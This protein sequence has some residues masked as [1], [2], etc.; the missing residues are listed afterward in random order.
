MAFD[1]ES[2]QFCKFLDHFSI[3]FEEIFSSLRFYNEILGNFRRFSTFFF[4]LVWENVFST[5]FDQIWSVFQDSW[6]LKTEFLEISKIVDNLRN[7]FQVWKILGASKTKFWAILKDFRRLFN[8]VWENVFN[9][10]RFLAFLKEFLEFW[11]IL[12]GFSI[13][14]GQ[15]LKIIDILKQN[16]WKFRRLSTIFRSN[17]INFSRDENLG[18]FKSINQMQ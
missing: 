12:D 6:H 5:F 16:F 10:S 3:L 15:F 7:Y 18:N 9:F 1:R 2:W 4:Y 14:L 17:L 11:D 13:Q 8:L